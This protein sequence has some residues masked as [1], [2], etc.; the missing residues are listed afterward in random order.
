MSVSILFRLLIGL[1]CQPRLFDRLSGVANS[2]SIVRSI[3][4]AERSVL[5][6]C[7]L[8]NLVV[9]G[10]LQSFDLGLT[11]EEIV[12]NIGLT[13]VGLRVY[14]EEVCRGVAT[15]AAVIKRINYNQHFKTVSLQTFPL[16]QPTV[17][18]IYNS[19]QVDAGNICGIL[20][21]EANCTFSSK[22]KLEWNITPSSMPKPALTQL[23]SPPVQREI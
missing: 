14:P 15:I 9:R 5:P 8:C 2:K 19:S 6:S 11:N 17:R 4:Q 20:M 7:S 3:R 10:I 16:F 12:D 13:C 18:F 23:D 1:I 21:Q 22:E